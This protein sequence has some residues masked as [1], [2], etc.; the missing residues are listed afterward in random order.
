VDTVTD[1][2]ILA[3]ERQFWKTQAAKEDAIRA[4]GLS[5]VRYYQRLNRLLDDP[6]VL[7]D[8]PQA[9]YRLRRI[10]DARRP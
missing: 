4:A 1:D 10:R 7:P 5:P 8:A 3:T 6:A 9:V 2:D